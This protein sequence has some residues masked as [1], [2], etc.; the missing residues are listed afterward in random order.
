MDIINT[1]SNYKSS[2]DNT[3]QRYYAFKKPK[4]PES[5]AFAL[6]RIDDMLEPATKYINDKKTDK[7]WATSS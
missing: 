1:T 6:D 2:S 7:Y 5:P 3:T 4:C